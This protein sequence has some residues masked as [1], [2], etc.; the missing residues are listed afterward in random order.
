MKNS[1]LL[2][3]WLETYHRL[4]TDAETFHDS[5]AVSFGLLSL[6]ESLTLEER[7]LVHPL[8]TEWLVSDDNR[9]RYDS[10]FLISQC[11]IREMIPAVEAAIAK[12]QGML[13]PEAHFET[14]KLKRILS[15][16]K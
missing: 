6:Y 9:L 8:L 14:K 2:T 13:G 1:P 4:S 3:H 10:A 16:L 15:E 5:Q 12:Y 7:E 11:G